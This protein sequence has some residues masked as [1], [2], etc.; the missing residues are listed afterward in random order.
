MSTSKAI[1]RATPLFLGLV[2]MF[3][4]NHFVSGQSDD[5][6]PSAEYQKLYRDAL[7]LFNKEQFDEALLKLE[8]ASAIEPS[9]LATHNLKGAV[10]VKQKDYEK[11]ATAFQSIID[12]Q[13]DNPIALFNYGEVLFLSGK[14][15]QAKESFQKYRATEGNQS[16]ALARFKVILCDLLGG[17]EAEAKKTVAELSPTVSHPLEYFGKA[18]LEF[19]AGNEK[20]A[21]TFLQSAFNIYPGGMNLAFADSFVELGWLKKGDVTQIGAVN[22]AALQSLS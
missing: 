5:S 22:A 16:N 20:K 17:N 10:Y 18:A 2:L 1:F 21:R 14:Y 6:P 7:E 15:A 3:S 12:Q 13:P 4:I 8:E 11:A 9:R 19:H